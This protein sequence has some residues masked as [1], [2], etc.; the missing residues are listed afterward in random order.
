MSNYARNIGR[1]KSGF[2]LIEVLV[3]LSIFVILVVASVTFLFSL[4]DFVSQY[5]LET[6][7]YRSSSDALEQ[8]VLAVRQADS[9]DML[10]TIED[11]PNAGKLTVQ[12]AAT[13]TVFMLDNGELLLEINSVPYGGLTRD[14]V[15]ADAFTVYYYPLSDG[16]QFVRVRI[17]LTATVDGLSKSETFYTGAVVRGAL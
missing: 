12:N 6:A 13:T 16:R 17:D 5:R 11:T 14:E 2:S 15:V 8:I 7:L 1:L 10:N 4:R 9:V 3:Y